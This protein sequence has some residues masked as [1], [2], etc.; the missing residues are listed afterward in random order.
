MN[1]QSKR[2]HRP[3]HIQ[4]SGA[5][6][7]RSG[8]RG[9][10]PPK[11]PPKKASATSKKEQSEKKNK[12]QQPSEP[13]PD[14]PGPDA[15]VPDAPVVA[16][17]APA[18]VV[19]AAARAPA[20]SKKNKKTL[21][22]LGAGEYAIPCFHPNCVQCHTFTAETI[23]KLTYMDHSKQPPVQR[24]ITIDM[25]Q[26]STGNI[27]DL[28]WEYPPA[29]FKKISAFTKMKTHVTVGGSEVKPC[30]KVGPTKTG[31]LPPLFQE[32]KTLEKKLKKEKKDLLERNRNNPSAR[33]H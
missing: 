20:T 4:S 17:P 24:P 25:I 23:S 3:S 30:S 22:N 1:Q 32:H 12:K 16:A 19:A 31:E 14:A 10:G 29:A 33:N 15:P 6:K 11:E 8:G 5:M 7:T 9:N 18:V 28:M 21:K 26:F 27:V 2:T 13:A